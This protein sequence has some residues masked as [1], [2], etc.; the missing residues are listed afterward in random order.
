MV[1][2]LPFPN[3]A[4]KTDAIVQLNTPE[5]AETGESPSALVYSGKCRYIEKP[6]TVLGGGAKTVQPDSAC[7]FCGDIAPELP[8]ITDGTTLVNGWT[9]TISGAYRARNPD[10]SVHHTTLYLNR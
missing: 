4:L 1:K 7:I 5:L 3:W 9:Y 2:K 8:I 10:G 6:K